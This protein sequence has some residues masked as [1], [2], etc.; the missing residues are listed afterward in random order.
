MAAQIATE[1]EEQ[2]SKPMMIEASIMQRVL[3]ANVLAQ[4][5]AL[6]DPRVSLG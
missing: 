3:E 4:L 5:E 1:V 6:A 2:S